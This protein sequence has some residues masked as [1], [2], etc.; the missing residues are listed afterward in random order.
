M[1]L[2]IFLFVHASFTGGYPFYHPVEL[3][4][5]RYGSLTALLGLIASIV[6]KGKV[7]PHV[8]A[9]SALNLLFWFAD[10]MAQ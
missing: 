1:I 5:I 8:A 7:R 10:A 9:I 3:F 2:W 6:G 4:C